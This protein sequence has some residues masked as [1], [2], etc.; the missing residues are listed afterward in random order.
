M[1]DKT[2][3]ILDFL[4]ET[5]W[6]EGKL[7]CEFLAAGEYNENYVITHDDARYVFRIN[8]GTQL[9]LENQIEYEYHVLEAVK[10]SGVTPLPY[11]YDLYAKNLGKGA[12]LM[13]YLPGTALD[14]GRDLEA[15]ARIFARIHRQPLDDR[16]IVQGDPARDIAAESHELIHRYSGPQY[17]DVRTRLLEYHDRIVAGS[18]KMAALYANE[19]HCIVNTEVNSG[20]FRIDEAR[21]CLVDWEK[22]VI[23]Y[24]YQDLAHFFIPTTTLWKTRFRFTEQQKYIFLQNYL[25]AGETELSVD[26]AYDKTRLMERVILLR[27]LSWCYMAY[28]EYSAAHRELTHDDTFATITSYLN[29]AECF[30]E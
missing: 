23:S 13:E 11:R 29:E 15:A 14:Y 16:L 10:N 30:L 28:H 3:Q 5:R 21:A 7:C 27:A 24:R 22:A 8:H 17:R 18:E 6:L 19:H 12:L 25:E 9:G 26:E 1:I 20:N 2:Q 4:K